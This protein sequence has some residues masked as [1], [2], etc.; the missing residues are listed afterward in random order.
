MRTCGRDIAS[1]YVMMFMAGGAIREPWRSNFLQTKAA[2]VQAII[3]LG[4]VPSFL[5][6][7]VRTLYF[8]FEITFGK[9]DHTILR[10]K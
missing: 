7:F 10:Y 6:I 8:A 9:M 4:R 1:G 3:R 2:Q 5:V